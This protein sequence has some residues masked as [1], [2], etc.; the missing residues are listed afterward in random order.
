MN[1]LK[2]FAISSVL[3]LV[4]TA[5]PAAAAGPNVIIACYNKETGRAR[6]VNSVKDCRHDEDSVSWN[7]MGLQGPPGVQGPAGPKGAA[8]PQGPQGLQ[9]LAG[10]AGPKGATG[11][12]GATGPQGPA[13]PAGAIGPQGPAGAAGPA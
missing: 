8:G 11:P 7:I 9:G 1:V 5:I 3:T 10:P 2:L 4:G 13:G 12:A 6:I